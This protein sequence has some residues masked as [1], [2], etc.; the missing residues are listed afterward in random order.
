MLRSVRRR[1]PLAVAAVGLQ[2][3]ARN[4]WSKI[5]RRSQTG[6]VSIFDARPHRRQAALTPHVERA[7]LYPPRDEQLLMSACIKCSGPSFE[8]A[9]LG[10][11]RNAVILSA[12]SGVG[13][14]GR[15]LEAPG[16]GD[17]TGREAAF[18]GRNRQF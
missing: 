13:I 12:S 9:T 18:R 5:T 7:Y 10:S 3:G 14:S 6:L 16:R 4:T 11:T 17:H 1:R 8:L 2:R 15:G